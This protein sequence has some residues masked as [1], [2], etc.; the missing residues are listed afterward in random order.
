MLRNLRF[1]LLS[2]AAGALC[3]LADPAPWSNLLILAGAALVSAGAYWIYRPA[4][5]IVGGLALVAIAFLMA[6]DDSPR[7]E[8]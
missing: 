7:L 1:R 4:G 2:F 6:Q 5:L 3:L 8:D